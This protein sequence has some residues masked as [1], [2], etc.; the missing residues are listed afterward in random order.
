[1]PLTVWSVTADGREKSEHRTHYI[2]KHTRYLLYL[3]LI[4]VRG[5]V[6]Y[7]VSTL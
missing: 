7:R 1:M 5:I 2:Y 6:Y 3:I 4:N